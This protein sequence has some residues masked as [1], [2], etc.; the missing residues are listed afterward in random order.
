MYQI[1]DVKKGNGEVCVNLAFLCAITVGVSDNSICRVALSLSH[2]DILRVKQL[3]DSFPVFQ[4]SV[5]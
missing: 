3:S 5:V 4:R 1:K 2:T